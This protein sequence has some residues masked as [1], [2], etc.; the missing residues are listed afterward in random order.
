VLCLLFGCVVDKIKVI[1]QPTTP[2]EPE[3]SFV[4][5]LIDSTVQ[6]WATCP[7]GTSGS[8]SGVVISQTDIYSLV[9]TAA[10]VAESATCS[11]K[12]DGKAC[13]LMK[14]NREDDT[15]IIWCAP[16]SRTPRALVAPV[17]GEPVWVVGYPFQL[18]GSKTQLQVTTGNVSAVFDDRFKY[19]AP[20]Y[21]GNSGG[22]IFNARGQVVGLVVLL[23]SAGRNPWGRI[24]PM[25]GEYFGTSAAK[26]LDLWAQ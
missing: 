8:G 1:P 25:P 2:P 16:S 22:P 15:A 26:L 14:I 11:L 21:F 6:V 23:Y 20:S 10:H 13:Y 24:I 3:M 7:D 9:A 5:G 4:E 17:L 12:V 18:H 19:S